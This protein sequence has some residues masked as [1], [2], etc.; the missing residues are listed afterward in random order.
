MTEVTTLVYDEADNEV[1]LCIDANYYPAGG[2]RDEPPYSAEWDAVSVHMVSINSIKISPT[3]APECIVAL[4]K[5]AEVLG[6]IEEALADERD[7]YEESRADSIRDGWGVA[8]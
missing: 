5:D 1:E 3:I 4:I 7:A 2:G 8:A 6:L